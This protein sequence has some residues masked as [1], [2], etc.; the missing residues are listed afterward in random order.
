VWFDR[1]GQPAGQVSVPANY[2]NLDLS[3]DG[4]RVAV[5]IQGPNRDIWVIDATGD[6]SAR[7]T[8]DSAISGPP[9]WAPDGSRIL[10]SSGRGSNT[11]VAVPN[12]LY[13]KSSSGAGTDELLF[14]G[15][16]AE[17]IFPEDWSSDGAYM[18]FGRV[19]LREATPA[20]LWVLP[21]FG[22]QKPFPFLQSSFRHVESRLSPDGRWLAFT[23]NES[24]TYQIV[25]QPFPDPSGGKW[26]ITAAGGIEPQ[27]RRDGGEL[28]YLGLDGKLMA[29]PIKSD[30]SFEAGQPEPLFQTPLAI[31]AIPGNRRYDVSADGQRFLIISPV[32]TVPG[33]PQPIP[34]T[35]IVN[36]A[37][38]LKK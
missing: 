25:V 12:R 18:I 28:F 30:P 11:V 23:T 33:G 3:P 4:G 35:A 14:A 1:N 31:P 36:W 20:D 29:V 26:Q 32:T 27:W 10:F 19:K 16:S 21:V 22:D 17:G 24:G 38:G 13:Q 6:V 2:G 34:I 8:L 9:V 5:E 7:L 37:V 15:D